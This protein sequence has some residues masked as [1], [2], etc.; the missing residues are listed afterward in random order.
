MTTQT[1][2]SQTAVE[3]IVQS[4]AASAGKRRIGRSLFIALV[5]LVALLWALPVFWIFISS[6]KNQWEIPR[7]NWIPEVVTFDNYLNLFDPQ[8]RAVNIVAAFVNSL[9]VAIV[10]TSGAL[11]TSSF[12]GYAFARLKF[13][14]RDVIFVTLLATVMVPGEIVLVPLF[15]QFH[16]LKLLNTFPALI[17]PHIISILGVFLMRQFMLSIPRELEEAA[18]IEGAG[19]LSVFW[20]IVLPLTKPSLATLAVLVFLGSWNDFL[21]PL[22]IVNKPALNTLPL[23]LITFRSAYGAQDYGTVLASVMF[24][25]IP[26]L[27]FFAFAQNLIVSSISR[28]GI[29]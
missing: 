25:V 18:I 28:T 27:L 5:W 16:R 10:A 22:I 29:K 3:S 4:T 26:P 12:A 6:F 19:P 1:E 11:I 7:F 8:G 24:A 2:V 9:I 13:W 14:G 15:L 23:A 17:A 20:R 21:W